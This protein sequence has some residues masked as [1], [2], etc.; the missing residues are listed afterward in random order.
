MKN[1]I[2][3]KSE[4]EKK[5]LS[6]KLSSPSN[7][8]IERPNM[9]NVSQKLDPTPKNNGLLAKIGGFFSKHLSAPSS[10]TP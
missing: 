3:L 1:T 2:T 5:P 4:E 10:N 7:K 6:S 9:L 8:N